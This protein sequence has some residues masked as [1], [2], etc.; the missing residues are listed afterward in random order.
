[1]DMAMYPIANGKQRDMND[2]QSILADADP[3][4]L[5]KRVTVPSGS[6]MGLLEVKLQEPW[7]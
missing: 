5:L 1:M 6:A 7:S 2:F 4:L 3:R